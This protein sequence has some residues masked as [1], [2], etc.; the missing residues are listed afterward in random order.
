MNLTFTAGQNATGDNQQCAFIPVLNDDVL[1]CNETFD[2][3]VAPSPEDSEIVNI[4]AQ[5]VTVVLVDDS[6]DSKP[7]MF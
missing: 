6:N 1:E 5:V 4:T 7:T 3:L 2:V